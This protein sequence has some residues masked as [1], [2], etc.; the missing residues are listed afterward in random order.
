MMM[1]LT[2]ILGRMVIMLVHLLK[3]RRI[4][5]SFRIVMM[6]ISARSTTVSGNLSDWLASKNDCF[7]IFFGLRHRPLII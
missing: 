3:K 2:T 5:P 7:G 1:V 4:H 6:M